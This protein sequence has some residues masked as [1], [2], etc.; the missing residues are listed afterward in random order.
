MGSE[1]AVGLAASGRGQ[2]SAFARGENGRGARARNPGSGLG[3]EMELRGGRGG[4]NGERQRPL[5]GVR[6]VSSVRCGKAR[7][8]ARVGARGDGWGLTGDVGATQGGGRRAAR[9]PRGRGRWAATPG[10][11]PGARSARGGKGTLAV[12]NREP[13]G[14]VRWGRGLFGER[15]FGGAWRP[16]EGGKRRSSGLAR[17]LRR[18]QPRHRKYPHGILPSGSEAAWPSVDGARMA[19][20]GPLP[21]GPGHRKPRAATWWAGAGNPLRS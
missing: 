1:A 21:P 14:H 11:G 2:V 7:A 19:A 15:A 12:E 13:R 5:H 4:G 3:V 17:P 18:G 6:S 9:P 16:A 20:R 10:R 8:R